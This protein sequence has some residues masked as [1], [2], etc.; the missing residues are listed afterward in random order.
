MQQGP[1]HTRKKIESG[2]CKTTAWEEGAAGQHIE[3]ILPFCQFNCITFQPVQFWDELLPYV[4]G[5][6]PRGSTEVRM[7]IPR[8]PGNERP[9]DTVL[10]DEAMLLKRLQCL[11]CAHKACSSTNRVGRHHT[12]SHAVTKREQVHALNRACEDEL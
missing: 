6:A 11:L 1:R 8:W 5:W 4:E 12:R 3:R 9:R 10:G 2:I 7:Y